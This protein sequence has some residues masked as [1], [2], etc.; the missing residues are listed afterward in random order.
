MRIEVIIIIVVYTHYLVDEIMIRFV[1]YSQTIN[2]QGV[3]GSLSTT[4]IK[5][6]TLTKTCNEVDIV[7]LF[8]CLI[9]GFIIICIT[10]VHL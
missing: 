6:V 10:E 2:Q 5:G 4:L 7:I 3:F 1:Q 9:I 8:L